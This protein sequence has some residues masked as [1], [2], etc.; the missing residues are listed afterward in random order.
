M[1][2]YSAVAEY[3]YMHRSEKENMEYLQYFTIFRHRPELNQSL[4]K[5]Q[6]AE[7]GEN[8]VRNSFSIERASCT[9]WSK[10]FCSFF[11]SRVITPAGRFCGATAMT[12]APGA[13]IANTL[14][15]I[16]RIIAS[17]IPCGMCAA[18][19]LR[20]ARETAVHGDV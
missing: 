12:C 10:V 2:Q 9:P 3:W 6:E 4:I 15:E 14:V 19:P 1:Y 16:S 11:W 17:C 20:I 18:Y 7:K 5:F 8:K 13:F